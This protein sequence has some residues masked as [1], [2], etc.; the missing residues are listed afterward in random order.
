MPASRAYM[1]ILLTGVVGGVTGGFA[2]MG[3]KAG[4]ELALRGR[5]LSAFQEEEH[6]TIE[7]TD[8]SEQ[9]QACPLHDNF[10]RLF[11]NKGH[12]THDVHGG[13]TRAFKD[14]GARIAH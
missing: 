1:Y 9:T 13:P 6:D 11:S 14:V 8:P 5:S 7:L 10:E 2:L 4:Q 12:N 3:Y